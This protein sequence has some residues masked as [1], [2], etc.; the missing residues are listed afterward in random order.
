MTGLDYG[1]YWIQNV[2]LISFHY[3]ACHY[4]LVDYEVRFLYV[5]HYLEQITVRVSEGTSNRESRGFVQT[6]YIEFANVL[7]V[8][9]E[10]LDHIVDE[11]EQRKLIHVFIDINAD[12]KVQ[13]GVPS[14]DDLVLSVFEEGALWQDKGWLAG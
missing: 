13:R 3:V 10:R 14:I 4:H 1:H 5:K 2:R 8:L 12:D 11:L 9:V 6:T 7:K